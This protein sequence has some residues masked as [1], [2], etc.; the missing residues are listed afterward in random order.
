MNF[1]IDDTM[2]DGDLDR[3]ISSIEKYGANYK[4][5]SYVPF[6]DIDY[7]SYFPK[8]SC[9]V[10]FGCL[11]M[12]RDINRKCNWVPGTFY[13]HDN[14]KCSTYYAYWSDYLL[15]G[16]AIFLPWAMLKKKL[17][18]NSKAFIRPDDGFKSFTGQ[19]ISP[20][21][22]SSI[23]YIGSRIQPETLCLLSSTCK[24]D[25]EYRCFCY[26]NKILTC[27]QY[28]KNGELNVG[29]NKTLEDRICNQLQKTLDLINWYPHDLYV[30]DVGLIGNAVEIIELNS[31]SCSGFYECD[32]DPIVE[33]TIEYSL[34][35]YKDIYG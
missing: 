24:L 30:V 11:N 23:R 31:F 35:E 16:N 33:A 21:D 8:D 28:R 17:Y 26:K 1:L 9:T 13:N 29:R 34:K 12:A 15:N 6:A 32:F 22:E 7:Y 20:T 27:S 19:V 5:C 10:F 4:V 25:Y 2:F 3:F 14:F 18:Q